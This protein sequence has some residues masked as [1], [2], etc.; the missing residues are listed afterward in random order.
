MLGAFFP[1]FLHASLY[2]VSTNLKVNIVF[3]KFD[4]VCL[5]STPFQHIHTHNAEMHK[6]LYNML[7]VLNSFLIISRRT[8]MT[9]ESIKTDSSK[10]KQLKES[11]HQDNFYLAARS[12]DTTCIVIVIRF[13]LAFSTKFHL[14][15]ERLL[16]MW[17]SQGFYPKP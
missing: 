17:S 15:L 2:F 9:S 7:K 16:Q 14:T 4:S 10:D 13:S 8:E 12:S 11:K 1:A 5:T 3:L 6:M